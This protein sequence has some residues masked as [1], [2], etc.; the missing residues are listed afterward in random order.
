VT[1]PRALRVFSPHDFPPEGER[2]RLGG[3]IRERE[4]Q[5]A[6]LADAFAAVT[7][8]LREPTALRPGDLVVLEGRME[9]GELEEA[10]VVERHPGR[11]GGA[12]GAHLRDLHRGWYLAARG[13]ALT[14]VREYFAAEG[15]LEVETPLRVRSPG[16]DAHVDAFQA[17][18][19]WL[20]TS[21]E[22]HMKRLLVG[23]IPRLYQICRVSRR[24]EQGPWHEPEFTMLEW[25]RAFA[26]VED[27]LA[28]TEALVCRL[29]S[30]LEPFTSLSVPPLDLARPFDRWTVRE[31]FRT[32][33]G[34]A[35][36]VDLAATDEDRYFQIYVDQVEPGLR[37]HPRPVF[38]VDYPAS[39][40]ALARRVADDPTVVERYELFVRGVELCNGYGELTDAAEQRERFEAEHR[41]R[42]RAGEPSQPGDERFLTA[43][44]EGLPPSS[45]NA[46]GVDRLIA[47]LVGLE[48]IAPV[49]AF[50]GEIR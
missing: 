8:I 2:I 28:D 10:T 46:L 50:P 11:P 25:Y 18:G 30:A 22:L 38:L 23:G 17:E 26:T 40:G 43:L 19:G 45:G 6:V 13:R 41:R 36:A 47:V 20:I 44:E 14:T 24:D 4:G 21:P 37:R 42:R 7:A 3:R 15:F 31:A 39:Q 1:S 48:C 35:D 49:I 34:V 32:L 29:A 33:A 16:L 9:E 5:I 12:E 27:T